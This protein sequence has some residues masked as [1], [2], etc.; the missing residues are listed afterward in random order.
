MIGDVLAIVLGYVIGAVPI[1]IVLG[2]LVKGIDLRD[3]GSGKMGTA[4][5]TRSLGVK[6]GVAVLL[7]DMGKGVLAVAVAKALGGSYWIEAIAGAAA[8]VGHNWSAFIRFSGGRGVSVGLGGLMLMAPPWGAG[9]LGAGLLVIGLSR[10]VSLGSICGTL[11]GGFA[12]LGLAIAGSEP[13]AYAAYGLFVAALIVF[14][15]RDNLVRLFQG[16]ERRIGQ[17]GER[18]EATGSAPASGA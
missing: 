4:N 10:Y 17:R 16:K 1:G 18:R 2:K 5:V 12:L 11:F 14:Q 6:W 15:H 7:L 3:Y 13:W 9:A 8:V